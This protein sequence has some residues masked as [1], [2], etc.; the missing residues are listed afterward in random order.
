MLIP[1]FIFKVAVKNDRGVWVKVAIRADYSL[2]SLHPVI[3]E[4][5]MYPECDG[6]AFRFFPEGRSGTARKWLAKYYTRQ[7]WMDQFNFAHDS[8][9][10]VNAV[11]IGDLQLKAR[12]RFEYL[13]GFGKVLNWREHLITVEQDNLGD[14]FLQYPAVLDKKG[15]PKP[16][17]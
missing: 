7:E 17:E 13:T 16:L 1:V 9:G 3:S 10:D 11:T 4:E 12:N 15:I 6:Y 14:D 8:P 2:E 5:F